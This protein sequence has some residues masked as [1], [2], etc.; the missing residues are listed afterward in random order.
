M[1][2]GKRDIDAAYINSSLDRESREQRYSRCS[3]RAIRLALCHAGTISQRRVSG[4]NCKQESAFACRRRS[5]IASASGGTTFGP[6]TLALPNFASMLGNPTTIALT[7]TATPDVQTDIIE[8]LNL[9]RDD[10]KLFHEGI[11]RPK[12]ETDGLNKSGTKTKKSIIFA[13]QLTTLFCKMEVVLSI[14][15]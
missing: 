10:V 3:G 11:E 4:C 9:S 2:C 13:P 5:R 14:S 15:H 1:I 6:I 8:Q 7:A 12:L